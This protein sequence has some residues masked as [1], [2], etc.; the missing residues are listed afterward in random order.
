MAPLTV[1]DFAARLLAELRDKLAC[2]SIAFAEFPQRV[3]ETAAFVCF[4]HLANAPPAL[5]GSLVARVPA[6]RR[7]RYANIE[8]QGAVHAALCDVGFPAPRVAYASP[9]GGAVGHPFMLMERIEGRTLIGP[10]GGLGD[11]ARLPARMVRV[12][13]VLHDI[14]PEA[15]LSAAERQGIARDRLIAQ[16]P[17]FDYTERRIARKGTDWLLP[18]LAWLRAHVPAEAGPRVIC[19]GDFHGTNIIVRGNQLAGVIDWQ[20]TRISQPASDV[21]NAAQTIFRRGALSPLLRPIAGPL[22]RWARRRYIDL[23]RDYRDVRDEDMRYYNAM[24]T[25][26]MMDVRGRWVPKLAASF[27]RATGVRLRPPHP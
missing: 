26:A 9:D 24:R 14:D 21:A 5:S 22:R 7:R 16:R 23:Y 15:F 18:G 13:R 20:N 17:D 2:P 19:H 6:L 11:I 12:Q 4:L 10:N 1:D 25:F 3:E 27:E 8:R